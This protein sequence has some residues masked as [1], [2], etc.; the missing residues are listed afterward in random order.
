M[1]PI[2]VDRHRT[3]ERMVMRWQFRRRQRVRARAARF[4]H[5]IEVRVGCIHAHRHTARSPA[6]PCPA[7]ERALVRRRYRHADTA[8][9]EDQVRKPQRARK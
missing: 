8:D 2:G 3:V 1:R 6:C 9:R 5:R 4:L 7:E